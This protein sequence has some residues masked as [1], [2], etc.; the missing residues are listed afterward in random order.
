M[1]MYALMC[2]HTYTNECIYL[3]IRIFIVSLCVFQ[4]C[5]LGG[6]RRNIIAVA[7][8]APNS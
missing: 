2:I 3:H 5:P 7:M 6:P 4:L 1:F 8:N